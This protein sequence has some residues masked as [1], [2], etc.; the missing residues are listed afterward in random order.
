[1][2]T[3]LGGLSFVL[4][5]EGACAGLVLAEG[6]QLGSASE[7]LQAK[8]QAARAE[9]QARSDE[10][11]FTKPVRDLLRF[12][13]YKPSGRAKPASE[14]LLRAAREDKFPSINNV[15]DL[16]N[17]V[18]LQTLLPL[19]VVDVDKVGGE[20]FVLRR[21]AADERYVF[22]RAGQEIELSDLL[23]LARLPDNLPCANPVKDSTLSK[24]SEDAK[25]ALAV[26]YGSPALKPLVEQA[27]AQLAE[28][29][30]AEAGAQRVTRGLLA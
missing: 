3:Q 11:S 20:G 4:E 27:T 16:G 10:Q 24:L 17:L 13:R 30:E 5:A 2:S 22:N 26:V 18:S 23:L 15:V 14:Y 29:F 6:I 12:G 1:M 7:D 19:S 21:G 28:L 8:L 25:T 9:A